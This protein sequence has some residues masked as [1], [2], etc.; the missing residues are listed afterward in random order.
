MYFF[1][2]SAVLFSVY[3]Y[4]GNIE[5]ITGDEHCKRLLEPFV[6]VLIQI[7]FQQNPM[8]SYFDNDIR[9]NR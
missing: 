6:C 5:S 4:A 8:S 3:N 2:I 1:T 7:V 9:K